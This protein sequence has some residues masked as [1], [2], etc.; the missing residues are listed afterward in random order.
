M[1]HIRN[2]F[3][4]LPMCCSFWE[5]CKNSPK[6]GL[7]CSTPLNQLHVARVLKVP[8][9]YKWQFTYYKHIKLISKISLDCNCM[10][11]SYAWSRVC[12]YFCV[13]GKGFPFLLKQKKCPKPFFHETISFG[14]VVNMVNVEKSYWR[15]NKFLNFENKMVQALL[16]VSVNHWINYDSNTGTVRGFSA[17]VS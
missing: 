3:Y 1:L 4:L 2:I 9:L 5:K 6:T 17:R 15:K 14:E 8:F 10:F 16:L 13:G 11:M 7:G 12:C